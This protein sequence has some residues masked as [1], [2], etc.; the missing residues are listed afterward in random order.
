MSPEK[1]VE[2]MHIMQAHIVRLE[3]YVQKMNSLQKLEDIEIQKMPV[4][5]AEIISMLKDSAE[6]V[7]EGK[8]LVFKTADVGTGAVMVDLSLMQQVYENILPNALRYARNKINIHLTSDPFAITIS[9][10]GCGFSDED[11]RNATNPFYRSAGQ[12]DGQHFGMGLNICKILCE[13]HGGSLTLSNQQG[14]A[15]VKAKF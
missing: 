2:T 5:K 9:D 6:I 10:D 3:N 4:S 7:C 1:V 8:T 13:R 15:T 14:G 11:L 12:N